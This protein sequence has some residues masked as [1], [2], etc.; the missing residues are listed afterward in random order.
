MSIFLHL[1]FYNPTY[2]VLIKSMPMFL[3]CLSRIA[4]YGISQMLV[5]CVANGDQKFKFPQI[6]RKSKQLIS[7]CGKLTL[8][9]FIV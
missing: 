7:N 2:L 4:S 6:C 5:L 8:K 9:N 3:P 1:K